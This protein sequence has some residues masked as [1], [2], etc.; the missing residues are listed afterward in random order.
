MYWPPANR[1]SLDLV[2]NAGTRQ[3]ITMLMSYQQIQ[4]GS[5]SKE[6]QHNHKLQTADKNFDQRGSSSKEE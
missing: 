4:G 2:S 3:R 5:S 1:S 6:D